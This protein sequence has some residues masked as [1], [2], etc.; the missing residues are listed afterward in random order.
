MPLV[1]LKLTL[2]LLPL[3]EQIGPVPVSVIIQEVPHVL[4]PSV[5]IEILP[6]PVFL[7]IVPV[8][9]IDVSVDVD[10]P[11]FPDLQ[12]PLQLT[13]VCLSVCK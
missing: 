7:V 2:K 11:P 1:P 5:E 3:R 9:I 6:V 10:V 8:P 4:L 13:L 12:A